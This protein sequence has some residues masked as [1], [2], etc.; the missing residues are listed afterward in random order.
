M[1]GL[2]AINCVLFA[3][4][5]GTFIGI[6]PIQA[7]EDGVL[8]K[9]GIGST[10]DKKRR[11]PE[12]SVRTES[13][14]N[15]VRIY[16]SAHVPNG[17]YREYPLQYDFYINRR[18]FSTQMQSPELPGAVGVDIGTDIAVPPFN[19]SVV[20]SVLHPNSRYT[21]VIH[22]TVYQQ[23]LSATLDC[24]V[25]VESTDDTIVYSAE[26]VSTEQDADNS[27]ALSFTAEEVSLDE[28]EDLRTT[29]VKAAFTI[30]AAAAEEDDN[31]SGT[32]TIGEGDSAA[33]HQT[34]GSAVV[35]DGKLL[36]L[37]AASAD[38]AVEISCL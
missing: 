17:D 11:G 21:T 3:A 13:E 14:E 22:G 9:Q 4:A 2:A 35:E 19:Y 24:T 26:G 10:I 15:V 1:R 6:A 20:A 25:T 7:Q 5:C 16:A 32:V 36:E 18:L 37:T 34:T 38:G 31:L 8:I 33:I 30:D 28:S 12:L 27:I 29:A 23:S